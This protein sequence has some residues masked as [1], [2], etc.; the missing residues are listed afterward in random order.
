MI[1]F[2]RF[3]RMNQWKQYPE[4]EM[5]MIT[6]LT[7]NPIAQQAFAV[8][9]PVSSK[10]EADLSSVSPRG[11]HMNQGNVN[12]TKQ[13]AVPEDAA[14]ARKNKLAEG[15]IQADARAMELNAQLDQP[16]VG[17]QKPKENNIIAI[18][19]GL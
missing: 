13:A 1:L 2:V 11:I 10:E 5:R 17:E 15:R 18:L 7:Q 16:T 6:K 9:L 3:S 8:D 14:E 4:E 19:I 12:E